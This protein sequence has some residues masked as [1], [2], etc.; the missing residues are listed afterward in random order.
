MGFTYT[1]S[2]VTGKIRLLIQDNVLEDGILPE[3]A[4]FSDEEIGTIYEAANQDMYSAAAM[5]LEIASRRWSILVDTT[6]GPLKE[7]WSQAS[8]SLLAQA[9]SIRSI[10]GAPISGEV[11]AAAL[12]RNDGYANS[13]EGDI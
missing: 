9:S 1:L 8:K 4:N 5:L 6:V 10:F 3:G 7:S 2:T 11:V 13:D 12:I